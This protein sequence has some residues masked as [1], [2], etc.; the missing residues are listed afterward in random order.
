MAS[1]A[2][3]ARGTAF[4]AA[5]LGLGPIKM[6]GKTGTAQAHTYLTGHG[7]H[8]AVGAWEQRDHGWF[9]AFAPYDEPRYAMAILVEHGGFGASAAAPKAREIMRT[10]LLKD[11]E[12]MAR[13]T[14]PLG[15][16]VPDAP[17]PMDPNAVPSDL[18]PDLQE[19]PPA[20][21]Q[22]TGDAT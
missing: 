13:I 6:A 11:P 22:K 16:K 14:R 7:A 2:N 15:G 19:Q 3:D 17:P 20:S 12:L 9:V 21:T 1:V 10:T 18:P 5:Q 4:A 8:G